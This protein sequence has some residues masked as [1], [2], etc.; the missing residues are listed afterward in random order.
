MVDQSFARISR[1]ANNGGKM[2]SPS[3]FDENLRICD[4]YGPVFLSVDQSGAAQLH[5]SGVVK[6]LRDGFQVDQRAVFAVPLQP[7]DPPDA[8]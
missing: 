5:Q 1:T 6:N 2:L 8:G 4:L 7:S 3:L